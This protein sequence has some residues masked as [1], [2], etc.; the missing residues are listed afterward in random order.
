MFEWLL[1]H[2]VTLPITILNGTQPCFLNYT[3][4]IDIWSNCGMGTDYLKAVVSPWIGPATD[5]PSKLAVPAITFT[6][7]PFC[8]CTSGISSA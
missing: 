1:I 6:V 8:K 3:A 7:P 5:L 2:L 4:G